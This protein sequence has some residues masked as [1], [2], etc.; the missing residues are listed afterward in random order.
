MAQANAQAN[1]GP[2]M[3]AL[4]IGHGNP[5][6]AIEENVFSRAWA[7]AA[8]SLPTPEAILCVSA[9]WQTTGTRVTTMPKP[10]TI[11]DFSGF[12][13]A[14]YDVVYPCPG[15]PELY[16]TITE[17]LP[18]V[19]I[20]KDVSWGLD[21]GAWSVLCHMFPRADIP[22][23]QLSLDRTLLPLHHYD[24][25]KRLKALRRKGVL[26]IGSGNIVHNLGMVTWDDRA[27]DWAIAF[28]EKIKQLILSHDHEA[29]IDY[30][31]MGPDAAMAIPTNEHYLP[32]LYI[33]ATEEDGDEMAFFAEDITLG[34][35]SMRC[36][37]IG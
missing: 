3:P 37:K 27:Y 11:Y 31:K 28:D 8:R 21:H 29:I 33:L 22:V 26:I 19:N 6:N 30:E 25:G 13:K 7:D 15:L 12:P 16:E 24:L 35:I 36:L 23:V 34:S 10:R 18:V 5:I 4:F 2:V 32:L 1:G 9:H 14:L 20:R 17:T